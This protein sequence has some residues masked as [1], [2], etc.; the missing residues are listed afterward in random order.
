MKKIFLTI[1]LAMTIC[2]FGITAYAAEETVTL[3]INL[4]AEA[5]GEG[6]M[7][8][9]GIYDKENPESYVGSAGQN[10]VQ[11]TVTTV[12]VEE[13]VFVKAVVL[14]AHSIDKETG[15]E[16]EVVQYILILEDDPF[17]GLIGFIK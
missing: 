15:E 9:D 8:L 17:G 11:A 14:F 6:V 1:V 2:L 7:T 13:N 3:D 12:E 4:S 16:K 10:T 5:A